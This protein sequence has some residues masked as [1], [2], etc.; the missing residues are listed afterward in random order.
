MGV[1]VLTLAGDRFL[2]RQGVGLLMN[3]GLPQWVAVSPDDY[4]ARAA[5]HAKDLNGL[6]ALRGGLRKQALSRRFLTRV[7]LLIT[8]KSPCG[9]CGEDGVISKE[10]QL[11]RI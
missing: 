1:P 2:S 6:A 9:R 7:A 10:V 3:A 5:S 8:L 11:C 4:V